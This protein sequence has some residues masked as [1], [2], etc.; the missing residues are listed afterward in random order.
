MDYSKLSVLRSQ[1][2]TSREE[3]AGVLKVTPYGLDKMIRNQTMT[4]KNLEKIAEFFGVRISYFFDQEPE[5]GNKGKKR[6]QSKEGCNCE[7][8]EGM[9]E[10][11]K[12][13]VVEKERVIEQLNRE[14]GRIQAAKE[15]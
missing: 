5:E 14:I 7:K 2:K 6:S 10:F 8:L 11:L 1:N 13:K 12:E 15:L 3:L 9:V 4:V